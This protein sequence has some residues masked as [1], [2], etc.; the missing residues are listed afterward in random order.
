MIAYVNFVEL[1]SGGTGAAVGALCGFPL[2]TVKVRLQTHAGKGPRQ[3]AMKVFSEI[4]K[5]ES[6]MGLFKGWKGPV[7]GQFLFNAIV[8]ST[9]GQANR[10]LST[11]FP[12]LDVNENAR[13]ALSGRNGRWWSPINNLWSD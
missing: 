4:V 10:V 1:V 2:D 12:I 7:F 9:E 13:S 5:K 8:F 11:N 6:P 3:G